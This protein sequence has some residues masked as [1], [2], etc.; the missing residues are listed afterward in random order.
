MQLLS[1]QP[2]YL[3]INVNDKSTREFI[4][5]NIAKERKFGRKDQRYKLNKCHDL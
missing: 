5:S 3:I 1:K 4:D 2:K